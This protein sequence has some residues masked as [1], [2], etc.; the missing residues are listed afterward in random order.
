M[1]NIDNIRNNSHNKLDSGKQ[2]VTIFLHSSHIDNNIES[3]DERI[4]RRAFFKKKN[5]ANVEFILKQN[6]IDC[7]LN[8]LNNVRLTVSNK[9]II[10]SKGNSIEK[11]LKD[12]D[13]SEQCNYIQCDYVCVG[14]SKY[15]SDSNTWNSFFSEDEQSG[16][17]VLNVWILL[18]IQVTL[19]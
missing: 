12:T 13:N 7:K 1:Y 9:M 11:S 16:K 4:Y 3:I 19:L 6:A 15:I 8:K 14:D 10:N 18:S 17:I 2:N 5:M